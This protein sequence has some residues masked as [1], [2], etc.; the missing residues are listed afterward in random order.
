MLDFSIYLLYRAGT[1]IAS[2]LPV[3]VLFAI[4]DFLGLGAWLLL[5]NYR[6]LARRNLE[7]AFV[8]EKSPRELRRGALR[9]RL[10]QQ[11]PLAEIRAK[12]KSARWSVVLWR[13]T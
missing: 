11:W 2:A 9:L 8:K 13:A 3:R 6:R 1:A 4:G 7:I 5:P 10:M 12:L